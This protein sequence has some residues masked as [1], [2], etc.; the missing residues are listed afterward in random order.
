MRG[1]RPDLASKNRATS[2]M[3]LRVILTSPYKVPWTR[4]TLHHLC[5]SVPAYSYPRTCCAGRP[6]AMTR[7]VM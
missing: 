2:A 3:G 5:A 7:S 1:L 6:M 4:V